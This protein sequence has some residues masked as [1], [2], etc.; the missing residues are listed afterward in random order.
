M[1]TSRAR[2]DGG[3]APLPP[4]LEAALELF[5]RHLDAE[6][7]LSRHTV[8]AYRGDVQSLLEHAARRG[9]VDPGQLDLPTLRGWLAGQHEAGAA[10]TTLARRGAAARVFTAFAHRR[11]WLVSDPGVQL[12]TP[13]ARR[14]LPRVLHKE[15]M[16]SIL[17]SCE[18]QVRRQ[19]A[20]GQPEAALAMRDA[21]ILEL[22]Y[23]SA[24]RVSELCGMDIEALDEGRRT[25][26]VLGKGNKERVVPVGIPAMRAVT[27]WVEEGRPLLAN[28]RSE[29]AL[30]I[31][32]RGGRLDPR[33]ARRVV[34]ARMREGLD[35]GP[36][37]IRHT[38]AT[39]LLEGGADLRSVQEILGHASPATTQIYT[40]VSAER[41]KASYRQAHPR[42]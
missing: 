3:R 20:Q 35:A 37:A 1:A 11:G 34:H 38:A 22:L 13:K 40:H 24:I 36:H 19:L 15:A 39:H 41:L 33:T 26:R 32:A 28:E 2:P 16:S 7:A 31:G 25:I 27:R 23:A 8:R 12:G 18:D 17:A 10:R 6:R 29:A 30:F 5:G 14:T 4:G 42:A 9:V 21:A